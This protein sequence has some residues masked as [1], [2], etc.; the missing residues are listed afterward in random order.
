M[1]LLVL[2]Y[3]SSLIMEDVSGF[4]ATVISYS[5]IDLTWVNPTSAG[6]TGVE[7]YKH[8]ASLTS[9]DR[10]WC[11]ANATLIYSGSLELYNNTG[12][13]AETTYF[14]KAFAV[15][16][17][18]TGTHYS[19][20]VVTNATTES[21]PGPENYT[22]TEINVLEHDTTFAWQNSA[23][24]IDS[25]H[26]IL[27]Y[28]GADDDG[29]IKTFSVDGSYAITEIDL[30][31]HDTVLGSFNSLVMIDST[32][33]VLAYQGADSDGFI[34]TFSIDSNCDNI[35]QLYSLEF[36]TADC[37]YASLIKIDATHFILSYLKGVAGAFIKSF[38]INGSY[39]VTEIDSLNHEAAATYIQIAKID[40][41]HFAMALTVAGNNG[42]A[43]TFSMDANCDNITQID[44]LVYDLDGRENSLVVI[45]ATHFIISYSNLTTSKSYL[46]TFSVDAN[47]DN[48]TEVDDL[49]HD[50]VYGMEGSLLLIDSTH[51]MLAYSGSGNDGFLK[52]FS[53]DG[54]FA[55]LTQIDSLEFDTTNARGNSL[56]K[57]NP[58]HYVVA[59]GG[60]DFDG[61]IKTFSID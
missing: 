18:D 13:D 33:F 2:P 9:Y 23:V 32:H 57:L 21:E 20:G 43:K 31:E 26:F 52:T 5:E 54:S 29:F 41:T 1:N 59:Y 14:Y 3:I 25:T 34:K 24:M 12:L 27:A 8:S 37:S 19:L 28:Q 15:Y 46:Q 50:T 7:I 38:S 16:S 4:V 10:A 36:D 44:S 47:C 17:D 35:T 58:T 30:L 11:D 49:E 22:I 55:T 40:S 48:I 45:D 53:Y 42:V 39:E 6:F 61:Y 60:T 51:V 56:I